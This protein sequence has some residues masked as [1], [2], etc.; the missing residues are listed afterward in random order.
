VTETQVD[1]DGVVTI[2]NSSHASGTAFDQDGNPYQFNYA[3]ESRLSNSLAAPDVFSGNMTD[4]F[5]LAGSG[6]A[7]LHNGFNAFVSINT[8]TGAFSGVPR[9]ER[10]DPIDFSTGAAHCDPL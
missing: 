7:D 1:K 10:G 2:I 8:T 5:S 4:S 3:N 9:S 6:H